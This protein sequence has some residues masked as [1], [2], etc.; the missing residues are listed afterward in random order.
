MEELKL[1][2]MVYAIDGDVD[3]GFYPEIA[4]NDLGLEFREN[5]QRAV[6]QGYTEYSRR[7]ILKYFFW[8]IG[9]INLIIIIA[10]LC[11][12]R[13]RKRE[14]WNKILFTLLVLYYNFGTMLLMTWNDFW[15]F[16][17]V[18]PIILMILFGKRTQESVEENNR[19]R[20]YFGF[21]VMSLGWPPF[22]ISVSDIY[23]RKSAIWMTAELV[24]VIGTALTGIIVSRVFR[25][26]F[27]VR[28][29]YPV[30]VVACLMLGIGLEKYKKKVACMA[31]IVALVIDGGIPHYL[32]DYNRPKSEKERLC[33]VLDT[34]EGV[35][36]ADDVIL[37]D[38][39]LLD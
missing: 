14:D 19:I 37:T 8:C 31:I 3:W 1:A 27:T 26:M 23:I 20:D 32:V 13:F 10:V 16:C 38:I 25:P 12:C 22:W 17:M 35:I 2:D 9:M 21:V 36:S 7:S 11:K 15:L 5:R 6:L 34:T 30:S 39:A 18:C 4:E 28:Y 33:K 24:S 29:V